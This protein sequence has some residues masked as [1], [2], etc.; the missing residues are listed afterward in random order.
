[1]AIQN[2]TLIFTSDKLIRT[3]LK[4][5]LE[6]VYKGNQ[7]VKII[8]ELGIAQG[9]ARIDMVVVNG[10]IHGYELKSDRD[11]LNRLPEQMRVY[12]S[13]LDKITLVVGKKHLLNAF[14]I[15]PEW[16]GVTIAKIVDPAKE[17]S[18]YNIR[19]AEM[20]PNQDIFALTSLLWRQEA[21]NILE[22]IDKADGVRS[23]NRSEVYIRLANVLD[24]SSLSAKV[25]ES[26]CSRSNWRLDLSCIP[27]GD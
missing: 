24:R 13:V 27:N 8:E 22:M 3:A 20:N 17:V 9:I 5:E 26:I 14:K 2:S 19:E 12:N 18:F 16:W 6:N 21:L 10:L 4:K 7:K 11:T 25:R 15:I 1:M 23:K